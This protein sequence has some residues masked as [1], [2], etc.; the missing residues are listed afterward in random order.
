M[1][2]SNKAPQGIY[3]DYQAT[4]PADPRVVDTMLPWFTER[5]GNPHSADHPHG[6]DAMEAIDEARGKIATLIG[7]R[8]R[9]II[10]TSGATESNNLA[11]KGAARH[12]RANDGRD[13]IV[14]LASEHKCVLESV[15]RMRREGCRVEII[16]I[17]QNGL[18][19]REALAAAIDETTALVSVMAVN[20]E[21]GVIQPLKEIGAL[22]KAAGAWLH[23]DAAQAFG[24]IPLDVDD[25]GISLMSVSGH[26]IYGPKGVGA[27]YVR[28]R[29]PKVE[30]DALMDGGG[31]ER[32]IRSGTLPTPLCVGLGKAAELA[33]SEYAK[34]AE[35][36]RALAA[37]FLGTLDKAGTAY[38]LNGDM[39]AR[40][41][42]NLNLTFEGMEG[43]ELLSALDGVSVSAGSACSSGEGTVSHVLQ[44]LGIDP[45][46]VA[47]SLRI[48][49]GRFTTEEEVAEA[50]FKIATAVNRLATRSR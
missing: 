26:K 36:L 43:S 27:L 23:T 34:E 31:Q 20:N 5:F 22:C 16:P 33:T 46:V 11:I 6:W 50:A 12:R 13:K 41:A 1:A 29:K 30:L 35:R 18:V 47:A 8:S 44:A 10:F 42:G 21:I 15:E 17:Q 37:H 48:G 4:T 7:A 3:L 28:G 19:N 49:F 45:G 40:I 32:G 25:M 2:R 38:R 14:T 39:D 24:K 9:E